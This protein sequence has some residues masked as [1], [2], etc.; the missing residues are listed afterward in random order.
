MGAVQWGVLWQ[1]C[2]PCE[3]L[4]VSPYNTHALSAPNFLTQAYD[5]LVAQE[6][7]PTWGA[8]QAAQPGGGPRSR[9]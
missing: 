6:F 2:R 9:M 1:A 3:Q 5:I 7:G 4:C 8:L